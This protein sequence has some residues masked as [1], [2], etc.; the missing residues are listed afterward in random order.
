MRP[1]FEWKG[2]EDPG[3]RDMMFEGGAVFGWQGVA[4]AVQV[5]AK[6]A[7]DV[8]G[9]AVAQDQIVHATAD[10]D[11]IHL[12]V[13]K[14]GEGVADRGNRPVKQERPPV[15]TTGNCWAD[16]DG[17]RHR[18]SAEIRVLARKLATTPKKAAPGKARLAEDWIGR[19]LLSRWQRQ[20]AA[21]PTVPSPRSPSGVVRNDGLD[22]AQRAMGV[23]P[24]G[25]P[26]IKARRF[27]DAQQ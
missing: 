7:F 8:A 27:H 13:T 11:G 10:I 21:A 18:V 20:N 15:E 26:V 17:G 6:A 22:P 23:E 14:V 5:A 4:V 24:R 25:K 9:D 1:G 12:H 16:P 19:L 3:G 2:D